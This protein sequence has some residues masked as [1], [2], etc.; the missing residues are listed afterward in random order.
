MF[1]RGRPRQDRVLDPLCGM[2]MDG[3][4]QSEIP[5]LVHAGLQLFRREFDGG[6]VAAM[7]E[8]RSG[9]KHLD[10]IHSVVRQQAN[11]LPHFPR[12]VGLAITQVQWQLNIGRLPRHRSGATG[13][14]DVRA[15]HIHTRADHV[16]TRN[17]IA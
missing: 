14:G 11:L 5:G 10:V 15:G 16:S 17:R 9:R 1:N 2:G 3:H 4:A 7:G 6:R 8:H 12:T 13:D